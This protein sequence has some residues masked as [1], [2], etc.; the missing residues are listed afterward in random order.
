MF[1]YMATKCYRKMQTNY[2]LLLIMNFGSW[3]H[4]NMVEGVVLMRWIFQ[5]F[6]LKEEFN[7]L[8]ESTQNKQFE[9]KWLTNKKG[10]KKKQKKT[11]KN[12]HFE[13]KFL[14][15]FQLHPAKQLLTQ[16]FNFLN[17]KGG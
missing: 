11:K 17:S 8:F 2:V 5:N 14:Q 13:K 16:L 4:K 7:I 3:A 6:V 15:E 12:S 9:I 1:V 10:T